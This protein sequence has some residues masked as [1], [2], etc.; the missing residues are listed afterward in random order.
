MEL[1]RVPE[2]EKHHEIISLIVSNPNWPAIDKAKILGAN[3]L[4]FSGQKDVA[5]AY[6]RAAHG[7][8]IYHLLHDSNLPEKKRMHH[9]FRNPIADVEAAVLHDPLFSAE[10][11]I[12]QLQALAVY[13]KQLKAD[14]PKLVAVIVENDP[15]L[16]VS[17]KLSL[18]ADW[19]ARYPGC[20]EL[21]TARYAQMKYA[22]EHGAK[23]A[24]PFPYAGQGLF[25]QHGITFEGLLQS[26]WISKYGA[27]DHV[28][29]ER[30]RQILST[31]WTDITAQAELHWVHRGHKFKYDG[32]QLWG[33]DV[34][35]TF[36]QLVGQMALTYL[37]SETRF[38]Q[39]GRMPWKDRISM[40]HM[41]QSF[42]GKE[43]NFYV[44]AQGY[45]NNLS[46]GT[47]PFQLT[48]ICVYAAGIEKLDSINR[49]VVSWGG[50][51]FDSHL[52]YY[53]SG[54]AWLSLVDV[55][56]TVEKKNR[57]GK[58]V[59]YK[60]ARVD[61][62]SRPIPPPKGDRILRGPNFK[63]ELTKPYKSI[64]VASAAM[65]MYGAHPGMTYAELEKSAQKYN[66][67]NAEI[68]TPEGQ[69]MKLKMR[70]G[71]EIRARIERSDKVSLFQKVGP[72]GKSAL[73]DQ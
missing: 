44:D 54:N 56:T 22:R 30:K 16:N 21:A 31:F 36:P 11:K 18:L 50:Q 43:T 23:S 13:S 34:R 7:Q 17:A 71:K 68:V 58:V 53:W 57:K 45:T 63:E 38:N 64:C 61:P 19:S 9:I 20:E 41:Y 6:N 37:E 62:H 72:G 10:Q 69:E 60:P 29:P 49:Q 33:P 27:E 39:E 66:G 70:Y 15:R 24:A 51:P 25:E 59:G 26:E 35:T 8:W 1:R 12:K 40:A 2:L 4:I 47:G 42:M 5:D 65:I 32:L 14:L 46:N 3:A 73:F 52:V 28:S 55:Q 67:N 48:G